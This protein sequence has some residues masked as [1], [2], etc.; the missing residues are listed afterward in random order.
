M[1]NL[2]HEQ[3]L[4]R[5]R[6]KTIAQNF[7]HK[8]V[9]F[10]SE[11]QKEVP[12]FNYRST[13]S[14]AKLPYHIV[15]V[16][17]IKIHTDVRYSNDLTASSSSS[18]EPVRKKSFFDF[19][20]SP[21]TAEKLLST[22]SM[23]TSPTDYFLRKSVVSGE[24]PR[25]K[26]AF[27]PPCLD[28][29]EK[30]NRK[31]SS[32]Q[33]LAHF[34][35]TI[36]TSRPKAELERENA[37]FHLSEAIIVACTQIKWN[38]TFDEKFKIPR[39]CRIK[40]SLHHVQPTRSSQPPPKIRPKFTVGSVEDETSSSLSS[41]EIPDKRNESDDAS[42]PKMEW[43]TSLDINSPESIAI[44]LM[45]KFEH[46]KTNA[47]NLL[48]MVNESQVPQSLLPIPDS[49]PINPDENFNFN[50]IRGHQF[51]APPRQQ[52][53]F[54]VHPP[55]DR[56]R[57]IMK[58][59]N[60]CAGCGMKVHSAYFH[61]FRY[62][63]YTSKFFCTA[64]HKNQVS[65][66]PARVL[67]KW[68]FTLN[69]VSNFAYKW[70]DQIWNLPLFH[71]SDLNVKLYARVKQLSAAREARLQLKYIIEFVNLCRFAEKEKELI[72][73]VPQHWIEDVDI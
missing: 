6:S 27:S 62:C 25:S 32:R 72:G 52:I 58:Q 37:H 22:T 31:I 21:K 12:Y 67:D 44:S 5:P 70:L 40:Q 68:D 13:V 48:W 35:H 11:T 54:T 73:R 20:E 60:R 41:E 10:S 43:N 55:P 45:S 56:K 16:E 51:W 30:S 8:K 57:Q 71:V 7:H 3:H 49:Y 42:V 29:L 33:N 46:Q 34:I 23:S 18:A 63:D 50:S 24:K 64:C 38:K 1:P 36:N 17:D 28:G 65:Q 4:N 53:I 19:F 59:G 66:I 9:S 26:S 2:S 14:S 69:P 61:K 15:N 39:D 47:E